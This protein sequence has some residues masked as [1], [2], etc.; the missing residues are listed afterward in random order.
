MTSNRKIA[1]III[2]AI[3]SIVPVSVYADY[4]D[5]YN[6][7]YCTIYGHSWVADSNY[8]GPS[9]TSP[10]TKRWYCDNCGITKDE[11]VPATGHK[12]TKPEYLSIDEDELVPS[13]KRQKK[14]DLFWGKYCTNPEYSWGD[15]YGVYSSDEN[16]DLAVYE[17]IYIKKGKTKTIWTKK[18]RKK[19]RKS[20]KVIKWRSSNKKIATVNKKTGKIKAKKAG[21]VYITAKVKFKYKKK[22]YWLK[23][24]HQ[25]IVK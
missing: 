14:Q 21:T 7:D 9:C 11:T 19:M 1:V 2:A 3:L 10:G 17:P 18:M 5:Y 24:D 8:D 25:I 20:F 16:C 12:W 23:I 6:T 15:E 13:S 22:Y 4:D